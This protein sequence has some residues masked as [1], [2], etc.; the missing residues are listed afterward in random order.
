MAAAMPLD[1]LWHLLDSIDRVH[2]LYY[3]LLRPF[4]AFS[5]VS[6]PCALPSVVATAA[7]AYG[8]RG[9]GQ[10]ARPPPGRALSPG[11]SMP[12]CRW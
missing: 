4:A 5:T 2:A 9:P 8:V 1:D 11:C 6:W 12:R 3:L 10:E 7:A